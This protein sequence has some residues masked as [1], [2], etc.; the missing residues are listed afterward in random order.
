MCYL[1][2]STIEFRGTIMQIRKTFKGIN[3]Q[4]LYDQ[5][6][7]IILKQGAPLDT[8][9]LEAYS[10]PSDSSS[11]IY[12]GTLTFKCGESGKECIRAHILGSDK[13]ELKPMIDIDEGQFPGDKLSALPGDLDFF[14]GSY[15][16]KPK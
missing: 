7:D 14:F 16:Q 12:R 10:L 15:E 4:V 2:I 9:K 13:S 11:F 3:P 8:H 5:V 1:V 6:R